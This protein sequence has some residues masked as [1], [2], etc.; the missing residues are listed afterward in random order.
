MLFTVELPSN[1]E[2]ETLIENARGKAIADLLEVGIDVTEPGMGKVVNYQCQITPAFIPTSEYNFDGDLD[3]EDLNDPDD[4]YAET[5]VESLQEVQSS[6]ENLVEGESESELRKDVHTLSMVSGPINLKA[7]GATGIDIN[8]NSPY[9]IVSNASDNTKIVRKS[10]ICWL[11]SKDK[12]SLSSDRLTR[13][14]QSE[15][16]NASKIQP[17]DRLIFTSFHA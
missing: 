13:V 9:C 17:Q 4:M 10:S 6:E 7:Y 15:V 11:L 3:S 14:K 5:E 1:E 8:E 2:I 12:H 16:I